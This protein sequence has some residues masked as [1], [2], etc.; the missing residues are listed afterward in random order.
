M[1]GHVVAVL[2][3][4]D[5]DEVEAGR[6]FKDLGFDSL[7]AVE[8][9]NRLNRDTGLKLPATTI[10]DYPNSRVLAEYLGTHFAP[11]EDTGTGAADD[12]ETIRR[13]LTSIPLN[14]LAEAGLMSSL[15]ELAGITEEASETTEDD[16]RESIDTMDM[17]AMIQLALD[18]SGAEDDLTRGL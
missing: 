6:A 7:T 1:R 9:R 11:Y 2:G 5:A 18:G 15:L 16:D 8:L 14:R 3:Y 12:E 10:F 4:A 13:M 17:E